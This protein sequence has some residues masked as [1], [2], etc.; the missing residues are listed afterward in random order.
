L[1]EYSISVFDAGNCLAA[2]DIFTISSPEALDAIVEKINADCNPTGSISI[3]TIGGTA[4][5]DYFWNGSAAI[6]QGST[7]SNLSPGINQV[8][9]VDA[10]GCNI[11][12]PNIEILEDCLDNC[13]LPVIEQE[14]VQN[15]TCEE[16]NGTINLIMTDLTAN[17]QFNWEPAVSTTW[18]SKWNRFIKSIKSDLY[19]E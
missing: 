1:V 15:S 19:M 12:I 16:A 13:D 10:N 18:G 7:L 6:G 14:I 11:I 9:I 5:F 2:T 3:M 8:E 4:P 17:Y